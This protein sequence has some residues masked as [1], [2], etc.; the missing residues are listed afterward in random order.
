MLAIIALGNRVYH[1]RDHTDFNLQRLF[2]FW[3]R[4]LKN[5]QV[6][7]QLEQF[8]SAA[9]DL[10]K[11]ECGNA[12]FY[13]Q[14]LRHVFYHNSTLLERKQLIEEHFAFCQQRFPFVL[15]QN[16]YYDGRQPLW[17]GSFAGGRL[18]FG[19]DFF[20]VDRKEGLM[21]LDLML[22][23]SRVYHIT[24][25]FARNAAG[26]DCLR[27]GALQGSKGGEGNIH[28]LTKAF[29]GFRPKN[30]MLFGVQ[31]LAQE[32]GVKRIYAVSNA[33]FFTNNHVRLDRKL[34]T[35]LDDFWQE[36]GGH[37]LDDPRFYELPAAE[38]RKP[39][40]EVKS[41]KRNL[42]RKRYALLDE[43]AAVFQEN[44]RRHLIK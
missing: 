9:A 43:V 2:V 1:H 32:L 20:Y 10:Q 44:L 37:A 24:F 14:L 30:L 33:G 6:V 34:R 31:L 25:L 18:S 3:L 7:L 22:D 12:I 40:E 4:A 16:L 23:G 39:I 38:C 8:F 27:I 11:L 35:S 5:S 17:E 41:Q 15:L 36:A 21:T 28:T 13:E 42:Y 19:L 26:E 29:F